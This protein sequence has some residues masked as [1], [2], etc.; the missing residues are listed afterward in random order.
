MLQ[1]TI[2]YSD[3]K[4]HNGVHITNNCLTLYVFSLDMY[5]FKLPQHLL[6]LFD[7]RFN[8]WQPTVQELFCVFT[9]Y[10]INNFSVHKLCYSGF[11][12]CFLCISPILCHQILFVMPR[13]DLDMLDSQTEL[14]P[15]IL[16]Y[17]SHTMFTSWKLR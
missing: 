15:D 12:K 13:M 14:P 4:Q 11:H 17:L 6:N 8:I 10:Q 2:S 9:M 16:S 5:M 3:L 7:S 1:Y